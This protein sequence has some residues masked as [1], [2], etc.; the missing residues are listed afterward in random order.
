M[1]ENYNIVVILGSMLSFHIICPSK[2]VVPARH[3]LY[4]GARTWL[5]MFQFYI[6]IPTQAYIET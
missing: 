6:S 2:V 1:V 5:E 3:I 4:Y